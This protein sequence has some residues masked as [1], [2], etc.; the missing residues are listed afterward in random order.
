MKELKGLFNN[1]NVKRIKEVEV[2]IPPLSIIYTDLDGTLLN[3]DDYDFSSA[4]EALNYAQET[5]SA[6][7][8]VTSKPIEETFRWQRILGISHNPCISEGNIYIPVNYL[9]FDI[10]SA[11]DER[12]EYESNVQIPVEE[13]LPQFDISMEVILENEYQSI[14]LGKPYHEVVSALRSASLSTNVPVR[15]IHEMSE[16]EFVQI[17]GVSAKE[18]RLA[19]RRR[20][21]EGFLILSDEPEDKMKLIRAIQATGEFSYSEGGRFSQIMGK[22]GTKRNAVRVLNYLYSLQHGE[23]ICTIGLGDAISDDFIHECAL[24]YIINNP[25]KAIDKN[26]MGEGVQYTQEEGSSAWNKAVLTVLKQNNGKVKFGKQD[27]EKL[28]Y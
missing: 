19:K 14:K 16:E 1:G 18:A 22:N 2:K 17:T 4:I 15:G 24:K 5:N 8:T 21:Q 6:V 12:R 27:C 3:H 13:R 20:A 25:K 26:R 23:N 7:I 9:P 10:T 11:I 28:N